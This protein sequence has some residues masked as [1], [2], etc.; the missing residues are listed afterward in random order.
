[1]IMN[2]EMKVKNE[3]LIRICRIL[4]LKTTELIININN[5]KK[6]QIS[7]FLSDF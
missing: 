2:P 4:K 3:M 6:I 1:M 7:A 5:L